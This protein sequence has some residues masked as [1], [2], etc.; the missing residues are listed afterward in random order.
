LR[1]KDAIASNHI[2]SWVCDNH[3]V[4]TWISPQAK[5][6]VFV[7]SKGLINLRSY[8]SSEEA[9]RKNSGHQ[10]NNFK[11][12][13]CFSISLVV[14][15]HQ[16]SFASPLQ[17]K[18]NLGERIMFWK[19]AVSALLIPAYLGFGVVEAQGAIA[20][21]NLQKS[22]NQEISDTTNILQQPQYIANSYHRHNSNCHHGGGHQNSYRPQ[23]H[24]K[25]YHRSYY[26]PQYHQNSYHGGGHSSRYQHKSYYGGHGG[27][28]NTKRHGYNNSYYGGGYNH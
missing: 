25:S 11:D 26:R 24:K 2:K 28:H 16:W 9:D 23:Y 6:R 19:L 18:I 17:P 12:W 27:G 14:A 7:Q 15:N 8:R 22:Q 1:F 13:N 10:A 21:Q 3:I 20:S 5:V 4:E